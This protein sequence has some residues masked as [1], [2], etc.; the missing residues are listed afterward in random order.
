ML[1]LLEALPSDVERAVACPSSGPLAARLDQQGVERLPIAG[2]Q[3]S[4][5]LHPL[6]TP[7]GLADLERSALALA[8]HA[9]GWRADVVHAN[10]LRAGLIAVAPSAGRRPAVVLQVHDRL[11]SGPASQAVRRVLAR[12]CAEVMAVSRGVAEAFNAGL[13]RPVAK[14]VH[15]DVDHDRFRPGASDPA[16]TRLELGVPEG[17]PLLGEVAQITPWKGQLAAIE[18]LA[19]LRRTHPDAILLLIGEVVFSGKGVRYDN[20]RYLETLHARVR[21]L[22][23]GEAVRFLGQRND[24]PAVMAALDLLLLPSWGEPFGTVVVEAMAV[25]TVPL[26]SDDGGAAEFVEDGVNG[27][28]LPSSRPE[29]WG[30]AAAELLDDRPRL[31]GMGRRAIET[32]ARFSTAAYVSGCLSAYESAL[33]VGGTR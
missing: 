9:R 30:R 6:T 10:G 7:R 28:T 22:G 11:T 21:E 25:G 1:R 12:G 31:A 4:F 8:R 5:R 2:T 17:A 33:R 26:V 29:L 16:A 14:V 20:E 23:L 18:A 3:L 24:I 13:R 27:R 15:I 32:A 19:E